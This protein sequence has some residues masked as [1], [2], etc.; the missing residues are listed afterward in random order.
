MTNFP[1]LFHEGGKLKRKMTKEQAEVI[2][3]SLELAKDQRFF[4]WPYTAPKYNQMV[5]FLHERGFKANKYNR[6]KIVSHVRAAY[7]NSSLR[8]E[9]TFKLIHGDVSANP[10]KPCPPSSELVI[11]LD[12]IAKMQQQVDELTAIPQELFDTLRLQK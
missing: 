6:N 1:E 4:S 7:R 2:T 12:I 5:D 8:F 9:S 3:M 10:W 11:G